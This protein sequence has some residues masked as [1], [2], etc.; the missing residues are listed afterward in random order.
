VKYK[1]KEGYRL[2]ANANNVLKHG[3]EVKYKCKEGYRL[4]ANANNVLKIKCDGTKTPATWNVQPS[5]KCES[6][7]R[8]N[9]N[10][11]LNFLFSNVAVVLESCLYAV[12]MCSDGGC[13]ADTDN[14]RNEFA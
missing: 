8:M 10:F 1:C 5:F 7:C 11:L 9:S 2:I 3:T 6:T 4:I 12:S 13:G 14:S